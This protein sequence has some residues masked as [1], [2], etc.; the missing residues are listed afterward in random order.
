MLRGEISVWRA[1]CLRPQADC[2]L[3]QPHLRHCSYKPTTIRHVPFPPLPPP[4][5]ASTPV[6]DAG[7]DVGV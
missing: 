5:P 6:R 1:I 4:R 2:L 7:W 3:D